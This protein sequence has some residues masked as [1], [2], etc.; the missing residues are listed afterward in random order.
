[1]SIARQQLITARFSGDSEGYSFI[2]DTKQLPL[3]PHYWGKRNPYSMI[4]TPYYLS[5]FIT[6][7]GFIVFISAFLYGSPK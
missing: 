3:Q 1:M 5:F 2:K 6:M 4:G 7:I